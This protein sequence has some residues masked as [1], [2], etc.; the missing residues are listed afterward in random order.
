MRCHHCY[1]KFLAPWILTLGKQVQPPELRIAPIS[2]GA[3]GRCDAR[4]HASAKPS[5]GVPIEP[6]IAEDYPKRDAA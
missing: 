6:S 5:R 1:H 4:G 3:S 2:R